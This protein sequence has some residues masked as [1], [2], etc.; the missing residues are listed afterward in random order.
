MKKLLFIFILLLL[1]LTVFADVELLIQAK[2]FWQDGK[3][4]TDWTKADFID[5]WRQTHKGDIITYADSGKTFG[6][7]D[8]PPVFVH[9]TV[10][11]MTLAQAK[12][13]LSPL[14]EG[15]NDSITVKQRRFHFTR[16]VVDSALAL[17]YADSSRLILTKQQAKSLIKEYNIDAIKQKIINRL[18]R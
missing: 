8:I 4:T 10:Q 12:D 16:P 15:V 17:W 1:P 6:T 2:E 5:F 11:G 9:I 3:P 14:T 18:Q 13:I 7:M